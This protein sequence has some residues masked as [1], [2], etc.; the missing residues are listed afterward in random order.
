MARRRSG[1]TFSGRC[2]SS[3]R[4][5]ATAKRALK[6]AMKPGRNAL[7]ASMPPTPG[8][9]QLLHQTVLKGPVD[10]LDT[11]L[12]LARAGAQDLDAQLGQRPA[13]LGHALAALGLL[14][15]YPEHRMLVGVEGD[16]AAVGLEVAPQGLEVGERALR[17]H[18]AQL[19]EPAGRVVDE[20]QQGARV[21]AILEPAVLA[22][23]DL[24]EFAQGLAA[25]PGLVEAPALLAGEPQAGADHPL[26]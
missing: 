15:G 18:E 17:R 4:A 22:A 24:D 11:A 10:P 8:Q 14:P 5:G 25:Q 13:E 19:H 6:R 3:G 23:V 26:A 20:D 21:G 9:P 12:R 7:P 1:A 2:R 16:G